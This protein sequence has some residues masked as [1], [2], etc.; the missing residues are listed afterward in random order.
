M[1]ETSLRTYKTPK[2]IFQNMIWLERKVI[3]KFWE[4]FFL[5]GRNKNVDT[6]LTI[7][8]QCL[9]YNCASSRQHYLYPKKFYSYCGNLGAMETNSFCVFIL[10]LAIH[11]PLDLK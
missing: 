10:F 7:S 6:P 4:L 9:K 8:I 3:K 5:L 2:L 1:F 11:T